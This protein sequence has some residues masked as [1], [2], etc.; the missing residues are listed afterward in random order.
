MN[1]EL[2]QEAELLWERI[3]VLREQ[4]KRY[5]DLSADI[6]KKKEELIKLDED[7][8]RL[9]KEI[10][11]K[12]TETA[13]QDRKHS[14]VMKDMRDTQS[15]LDKLRLN[16][17]RE[18]HIHDQQKKENEEKIVHI[19]KKIERSRIIL[20]EYSQKLKTAT[21]EYKKSIQAIQED[22]KNAIW[23]VEEA[24]RIL[25][26]HESDINALR[27]NY[28]GLQKDYDELNAEYTKLLENYITKI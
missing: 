21:G 8:E 10:D 17:E 13:N 25:D 18:A 7:K 6:Q 5:T 14:I 28:E 24:K 22:K 16:I 9:A 20:E 3:T 19:D 4:E 26:Q 11:V 12:R 15:E 23:D 27:S 2:R 1:R